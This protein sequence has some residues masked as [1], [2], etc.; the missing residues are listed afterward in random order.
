MSFGS[1]GNAWALTVKLN[2]K[3][4]ESDSICLEQVYTTVYNTKN[5]SV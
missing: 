4:K 1:K 3:K 2:A 5:F